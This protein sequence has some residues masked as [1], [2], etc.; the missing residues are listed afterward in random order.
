[1]KLLLALAFAIL[2]PAAAL[3][4][5]GADY[6]DNCRAWLGLIDAG[7]YDESWDTASAYFQSKITKEQWGPLI[8]SVRDTVGPV[9]SRSSAEVTKTDVL[10][11]APFAHYLVIVIHTKFAMNAAATETVIMKMENGEWKVAGYFIK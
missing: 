3:A 7:R 9:I 6:A 4:Q 8:K 1:M 11:N 10:P 2:L 5:S